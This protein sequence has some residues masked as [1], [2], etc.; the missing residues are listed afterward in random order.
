M[1]NPVGLGASGLTLDCPGLPRL[2]GGWSHFTSHALIAP[3]RAS[4]SQGGDAIAEGSEDAMAADDRAP[5]RKRYEDLAEDIAR[6]IAA[7]VL[8]PGD[9]LPSI[10]QTCKARH[11]S[12]S[13]VFQAYDLLENRG[14][15]RAAPRSG[16]FVNPTASAAAPEPETSSPPEGAHS[17]EITDLVYEILNATR[18]RRTIQLGSAFPSPLLFPHDGLR[19]AL[20]SSTRKLDVWSTLDDMPPGNERLRRQIAR[21]YLTQGFELDAD[22]IVLTNGGLDAL[23]MCVEAVTRPGD[24]VVVESPC[25]YAALQAL[26]RLGLR[27]IGLPTHPRNGVDLSRLSHV[28]QTQRPKAC[29]FM[30]NFQNPLGCSLPR[31]KKHALVELLAKHEVPLIEDDVY[32]EL[33]HGNEPPSAAKTFDRRGL[34]MHCSSFS[35]TLAPG[36]RIGWVAA[37]RFSPKVRRLKLMTSLSGSI[38]TQ[39]ALAEYLQLGAYDRHL[40]RLRE[41]LSRQKEAL[42]DA[43]RRHF[44]AG[45][46][47]TRPDGGYFLWVDMPWDT[48]DALSVFRTALSTQISVAPGPMFSNHGEFR[49]CLR[50]NFGHPWTPRAEDA[51][52]TLGRIV[53]QRPAP[54]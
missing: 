38:P 40:R 45:V 36:Y 16:Y 23:N 14:L 51:V 20:S 5:E 39:A 15:I 42:V 48:L 28:L 47:L 35:K 29:W 26:E 21:R 41:A 37:G 27:A 32:G 24:A 19:R 54:R 11:V 12:P 53:R 10:R 44:P 7:R 50:L 25:F 31:E 4:L 13:T 6:Q 9:R 33:H 1:G 30:T 46:R 2:H 34:V 22:E 49:N 17:V 18:S 8:R 3:P 43:V 52:A